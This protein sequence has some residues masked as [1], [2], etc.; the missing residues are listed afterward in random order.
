MITIEAPALSEPLV[1]AESGTIVE[2]ICEF[3][4]SASSLTLLTWWTGDHFG[5]SLVPTRF[6]EGKE[7][8]IGGETESWLRYRHYMHYAEGSI[9]PP[10]LVAIL[11]K[12]GLT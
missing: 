12:G 8:Q 9:F 2:Y 3:G 10:L 7:G 11:F 1:M 4:F 6:R 5:R